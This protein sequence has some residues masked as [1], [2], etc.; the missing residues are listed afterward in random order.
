MWKNIETG[1]EYKTKIGALL[2]THKDFYRSFFHSS[3]TMRIFSAIA[4]PLVLDM[5]LDQLEKV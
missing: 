4:T 5:Y 2:S 3:P 1:K